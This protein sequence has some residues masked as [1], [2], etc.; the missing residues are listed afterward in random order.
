MN[1]GISKY[2]SDLGSRTILTIYHMEY[3]IIIK[4]MDS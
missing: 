3:Y 4:T 1:T 2:L